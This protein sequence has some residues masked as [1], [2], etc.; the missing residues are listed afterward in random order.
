MK[1]RPEPLASCTR[2]CTRDLDLPPGLRFRRPTPVV[3][4]RTRHADFPQAPQ[5]RTLRRG[6]CHVPA[7]AHFAPKL[8]KMR[9]AA[10][11]HIS[12][13]MYSPCTRGTLETIKAPIQRG[14]KPL[15]CLR[16]IWLR[17]LDL[18][19]RPSGY[20]PDELPGCSTPRHRRSG[21]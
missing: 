11:H 8:P 7:A 17:G 10:S 6:P 18:N 1:A 5:L 21:Q 20:E 2:G 16:E 4:G 12:A 19:Q 9:L 15:I 14:A 13:F 3:R